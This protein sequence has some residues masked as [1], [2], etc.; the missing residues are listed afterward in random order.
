[1]IETAIKEMGKRKKRCVRHN[2]KKRKKKHGERRWGST[3]CSGGITL[4][5]NHR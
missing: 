1:M 5:N 4:R 3:S 2:E